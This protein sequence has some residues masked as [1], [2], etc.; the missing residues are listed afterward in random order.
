M[1][2]MTA[3]HKT[4]FSKDQILLY[5]E[6][7][8]SVKNGKTLRDVVNVCYVNLVNLVEKKH[9]QFEVDFIDTEDDGFFHK[10]L[11]FEKN[12]TI[13]AV[14]LDEQKFLDYLESIHFPFDGSELKVKDHLQ[15][16]R[17]VVHASNISFLSGALSAIVDSYIKQDMSSNIIS[18]N[19]LRQSHADHDLELDLIPYK[20]PIE[21][22]SVFP[23]LP[24]T[25]R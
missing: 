23:S 22:D 11:K 9:N 8:D 12:E 6:I 16:L 18:V 2:M 24:K 13:L 5:F 21:M 17:N 1:D 10:F 7:H 14:Y 19:L 20:T 4:D 25:I 15:M 3:Q